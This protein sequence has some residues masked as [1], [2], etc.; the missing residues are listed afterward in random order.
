MEFLTIHELSRLSGVSTATI[1]LDI[2]AGKLP[3]AS[4]G[5]KGRGNPTRIKIADLENSDRILYQ[6]LARQFLQHGPNGLEAYEKNS[7]KLSVN[8]LALRTGLSPQVV[9]KDIVEGKLKAG[10]GGRRGSPYYVLLEDLVE[11][12]RVEYRR[13]IETNRTT[14]DNHLET[15]QQEIVQLK[16]DME[17]VKERLYLIA[18][19]LEGNS[20][21]TAIPTLESGEAQK[22]D[23]QTNGMIG[24]DATAVKV[25]LDEI[26]L[27]TVYT[28]Y[29]ISEDKLKQLKIQLQNNVP[30]EPVI[31]RQQEAG[32]YL[33][34]KG[35]A[36]YHVAKELRLTEL[37]AIIEDPEESAQK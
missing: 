1:R 6:Q 26:I 33:L 8:E 19:Y 28:N 17:F 36:Q 30:L 35:I 18:S 16:K 12:K 23:S 10:G 25:P 20:A 21:T 22:D 2:K 7:G 4:P 11:A 24:G 29:Y 27:P 31:V 34:R 14:R 5:R 13:L 37:S 15:I 3:V 32:A 9:R